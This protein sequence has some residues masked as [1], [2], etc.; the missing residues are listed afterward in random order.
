MRG[1]FKP[2]LDDLFWH[3]EEFLKK[4]P[5]SFSCR[6]FVRWTLSDRTGRQIAYICLLYEGINGA[7]GPLDS[8]HQALMLRLRR[9]AARAGYA[10]V[11]RVAGTPPWDGVQLDDEVYRRAS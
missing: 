7:T 9:E 2:H 11:E 6:D 10:E 4:H 1:N 8:A 3:F 5:E